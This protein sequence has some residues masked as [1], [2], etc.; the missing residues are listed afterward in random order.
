MFDLIHVDIWGPYRTS[1]ISGAKYF[2]TVV[3]DFSRVV[4]VYLMRDKGQ[5]GD[6]LRTFC[7]M[8]K[9][10][11]GKTVK[12]IR[13]DNG[14]EF[15]SQPMTQYL[16]QNGILQQTSM[17]DTLEQNGWVERKHRHILEVARALRFQAHLPIEFWGEY[18]LTAAHLINRTP[19]VILN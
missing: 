14:R 1:T 5:T 4:W 16:T 12:I 13:S 3:D 18:M 2:L 10:Q 11:F 19:S 8:V 17:V 6:L 9:T 15:D 7:N